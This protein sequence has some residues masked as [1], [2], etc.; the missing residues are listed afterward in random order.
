MVRAV[1][2][3][4]AVLDADVVGHSRLTE[5][6]E[7]RWVA[8]LVQHRV[9]RLEPAV[10]RHGGRLVELADDGV[11]AEFP[12]A[13]EALGAAIEFQQAMADA[14]RG[15]PEATAVVFRLGLH[16]GDASEVGGAGVAR[17]PEEQAQEQARR[18]GIVVSAPLRDAVAGRVRASF[19]ELGSAGL[20][21]VE[22]PIH[23]YEVGWDPADWPAESAAA[24]TTITAPDEGKRRSLWA[25]AIAGGVLAAVVVYL[26][27]APRPPPALAGLGVERL[28]L[29][30]RAAATFSRWQQALNGGEQD[31]AD[32][33]PAN[34]DNA[35]PADA[36]DGLYTGT[37]TTRADSHVVSFKVKV[38][39]GIG[40]G[41]QSRL[42][43]GTAPVA[44]KISPSGDVSGMALMFGSTCLK[45]EL[46][47][48]GRAV[49]GTLRLR[50]GSQFL[51]LSPAD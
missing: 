24:A 12:S 20:G 21:T 27:S 28:Q 19:A 35:P 36:Y 41:T 47:I 45:T 13:A 33:E 15:Q 46:A 40:S 22:R 11:R 18:G 8:R 2:R 44:L 30:R 39:N 50:L 17:R 48:R 34:A 51:E 23:A 37:A 4:A 42:D 49:A 32:D 6:H 25:I 10:A 16:L 9:E 7:S 14:N 43:C 5:K 1:R 26:A 3:M 31:E 38:T 29:E